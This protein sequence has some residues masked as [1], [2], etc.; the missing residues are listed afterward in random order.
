MA[1]YYIILIKWHYGKSKTI[2]TVKTKTKTKQNIGCKVFG[3]RER[4]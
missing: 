1:V 3:G 4:I 2:Q